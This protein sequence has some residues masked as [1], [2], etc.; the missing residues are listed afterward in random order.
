MASK[1]TIDPI[2]GRWYWS[3]TFDVPVFY[4]HMYTTKLARC[5]VPQLRSG[6]EPCLIIDD[7]WVENIS[8]LSINPGELDY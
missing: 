5:L 2:P 1:E 7:I 8:E 6:E 4:L 3:N